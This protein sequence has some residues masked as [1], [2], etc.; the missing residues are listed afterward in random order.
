[1][2]RLSEALLEPEALDNGRFGMAEM[3]PGALAH[4]VPMR[5]NALPERQFNPVV[6]GFKKA[7]IHL[8][9]Y[10]LSPAH[11]RVFY[12]YFMFMQDR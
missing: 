2:A 12:I 11:E 4:V 9:V 7:V 3:R 8:I 1:M 5:C 10:S 6:C